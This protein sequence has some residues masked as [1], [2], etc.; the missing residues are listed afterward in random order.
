MTRAPA[1]GDDVARPSRYPS[2]HLE[3]AAVPLALVVTHVLRPGHEEAFDALVAR[4]LEG[5]R[6]DEPGTL[7]YVSHTDDADPLR[8]IFYELYTDRAAFEAHEWQPH[9]REF[10]ERRPG[11]IRSVEVT[12]L[13]AVAGKPAPEPSARTVT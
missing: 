8:R 11:H 6:R 12:F 10:L 13:D 4:T 7:V 3:D 9:V 2:R 5:I 1:A